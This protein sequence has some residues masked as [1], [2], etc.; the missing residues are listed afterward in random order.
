MFCACNASTLPV[1]PPVQVETLGVA[2]LRYETAS[3]L[4]LRKALDKDNPAHRQLLRASRDPSECR[5]LH[6]R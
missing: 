2:E 1:L 6:A 4:M 3:T 5:L